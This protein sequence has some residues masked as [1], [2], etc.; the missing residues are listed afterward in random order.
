MKKLIFFNKEKSYHI[1]GNSILSTYAALILSKKESDFY[2]LKDKTIKNNF[3]VFEEFFLP[4]RLSRYFDNLF[5]QK[6]NYTLITDKFIIPITNNLEKFLKR[7]ESI[8]KKDEIKKFKI[9][10]NSNKIKNINFKE[11][12]KNN[13][14]EV[15]F[16]IITSIPLVYNF[17]DIEYLTLKKGFEIIEDFFSKNY[18]F[19]IDMVEKLNIKNRYIEVK[20]RKNIFLSDTPEKFQLKE[21]EINIITL[22][23]DLK[24]LLPSFAIFYNSKPYIL[25]NLKLLNCYDIQNFKNFLKLLGYPI[26]NLV[27]KKEIK[28]YKGL[29]SKEKNYLGKYCLEPYNPYDLTNSAWRFFNEKKGDE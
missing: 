22:N 6:I 24:N 7:I 13:F 4:E 14:S 1:K 3:I 21:L 27:E 23:K 26:E 19:T 20:E 16:K 5:P 18:F 17:F 9:L 10:L 12:V 11:Y 8:V 2:Y 28:S 15:F 29:I 25:K